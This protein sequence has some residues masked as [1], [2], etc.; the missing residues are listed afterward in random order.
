MPLAEG[1]PI[2]ENMKIILVC[3][4]SYADSRMEGTLYHGAYPKGKPFQSL[5][6]LILSV[7]E[8]LNEMQFPNPSTQMR[9]F[10]RREDLPADGVRDGTET[11]VKSV[12]GKLATFKIRILF[13][14]NA[15]WQG[16]VSWL[17]GGE[18]ETFRSTLELL[19]LMDS[20]LAYRAEYDSIING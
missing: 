9:R 13:R 7:E 2:S 10:I 11:D 20:S 6:Q 3:V 17:E 8:T 19:M 5:M 15:S 4:D 18:E 14:Q 1:K 12:C 16:L